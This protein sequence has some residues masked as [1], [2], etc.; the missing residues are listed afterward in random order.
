M[1]VTSD[2]THVNQSLRSRTE[3]T[4]TIRWSSDGAVDY[5][6]YST[7]DGDTWT[8]VNVGDGMTGTYIIGGLSAETTYKVRTRVRGKESQLTTDSGALEVTTIAYPYAVSM[9]DFTI[10]ERMTIGLYNPLGRTVTIDLLGTDG[11]VCATDTITGTTISGYNNETIQER[12]YA[13]IPSAKSGRYYV[14]VTYDGLAQTR[15][16]GTYT[17]DANVCKPT[18]GGGSYRDTNPATVAITGDDQNVIQG[19]SIVQFTATGLQAARSAIVRSCSVTVNGDTYPMISSG[20]TATGGNATIDSGTDVE[21]VLTVTDSRGLTASMAVTVTILALASP[22][23]IITLQRQGN[24]R[25][26]TDITVDAS[27]SSVGGYNSIEITYA[28]TKDGDAAPSVSGTLANNVGT[29]ITL[30]GDYSW[31]VAV[32]L[33]DLFGLTTIYNLRVPRGTPIIYFDRLLS[34]VGI[35]CFPRDEMSLEVSGVNL[36]RNVMSRSLGA[37]ITNLSVNAYTII[38][39]DLQ[40]SVGDRLTPTSDGGVRVGSGVRNA[41]VSGSMAVEP[42]TTAG[43]RRVMIAKNSAGNTLGLGWD[44]MQVGDTE[45]V[46]I[47]PQLVEVSEGDTIYLYY[48]T[49][50]AADKIGGS[51]YGGRTSLTVEV[52]G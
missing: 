33:V 7:D 42:V 48:Y 17:V 32:T 10:G 51:A 14:K 49:S 21:A 12:L 18:I 52:M 44:S 19:R 45:T 46:T 50:N 6:W 47:P 1:A 38:P 27:Y 43:T 24:Y 31:G 2:V 16:G 15:T 39:L 26:E 3:T 35:N 4:V 28:C 20:S 29:T 11:S 37:Q 36:S 13:S 41:L 23:A 5:L 25:T 22:S 30:D 8:G 34:S 40:A 9:P